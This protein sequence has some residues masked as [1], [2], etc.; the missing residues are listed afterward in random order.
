[1]EQTQ[2]IFSL[3]SQLKQARKTRPLQALTTSLA[4]TK[5]Q[6][7][8]LKALH[9]RNFENGVRRYRN[10]LENK[11]WLITFEIECRLGCMP[12][13]ANAFLRKL[14]KLKYIQRRP[15]GNTEHY[16]KNR[17]WEYMWIPGQ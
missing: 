10:V 13:A 14:V 9:H 16:Y 4:R 6:Q 1:M 15:R 7:E 11:G 2:Q 8:H 5:A 12:T 17:G 3:S